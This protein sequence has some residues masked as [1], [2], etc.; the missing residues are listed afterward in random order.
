MASG[1]LNLSG[2]QVSAGLLAT[3]TGA[4]AASYLG[5]GGTLIG[6]AIGSLASTV[7][8]EVYRHYLGRGHEKLRGAVDVRRHRSA[9]ST[10]I[11]PVDPTAAQNR[12]GVTSRR[13]DDGADAAETQVLHL[14]HPGDPGHDGVTS[15]R[16]TSPNGPNDPEHDS[17][18]E[19]FATADGR[20]QIFPAGTPAADGQPQVF[21]AGTL[22]AEE[23]GGKGKRPRWLVLTAITVGTFL[24]A[25]AA[26]TV[27]E[28]SVGKT[29]AA[30]VKDRPGSGTTISGV[31]GG[32][33]GKPSPAGKPTPT[34]SV[35]PTAT[36]SA[37]V[38]VSSAS[39][40]TSASAT[41]SP[42]ATL[43]PGGPNDPLPASPSP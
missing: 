9:G 30:V 10:V 1:R 37:R 27:F 19:T 3:L 14:P 13:Q 32:Q 28:L 29:L 2:I 5:V 17:P 16:T 40:P 42:S 11:G 36:P 35:L 25:V 22:T 7:G 20:P 24:I 34:P 8:G 15:Q 18:T 21:P 4:V 33:T 23:T 12:L 26:I 41:P 31:T 38:S 6:A 43:S 39:S